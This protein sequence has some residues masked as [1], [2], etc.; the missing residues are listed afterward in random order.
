MDYLLGIDIGT[1]GTKSVL[2]DLEG[3]AIAS[4]LYEYPLYQPQNGWAEQDPEDWWKAVVQS[5]QDI[6]AESGVAPENII[7]IGLSGQM[8]GLVMLDEDCQVIR[9]S[10][11]WCDQRTS[12]ECDQVTDLVGRERLLEISANPALAG[13]TASK[14]LWVRNHEPENY[15]R[16]KKILLPKDYIRFKLTGEFATEVSDASGMQLLDIGNRCWSEEIL[17]RLNIDID[18]LGK[19]FESPE[20]TGKVTPEASTVTGLAVGTAVV[21]G[22]GDN[23]A[24]AVGMGVVE[25]GHAFA[26]IGTSGVVYAHTSAMRFDPLGRVHTFCCAVPGEWHVMGVTQAAGLSLQWFRNNF[27]AGEIQE[28]EEKGIDP[29]DLMINE[30]SAIPIGSNR[31]LYLPYL[32]GERTPHLD[33]DCRGVFFGLSASHTRADLTRAIMEGVT[34]SLFDSV[35]ILSEMGVA[36]DEI[37]ATGGGAK[38]ELWRM[39]MADVFNYPVNTVGS[40]SGPSLGVAILA[41]VGVGAYSSVKDACKQIIKR[42]QSVLTKKNNNEKYMEFYSIYHNLYPDLS[43]KFKALAKIRKN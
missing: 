1:S 10:I 30:A 7:G 12:V 36:F 16:C 13:F 17:E 20:V 14:I 21:G 34:F 3:G 11:I 5:C 35:R 42:N 24:S 22:A 25:D 18:L 9:R 29:Y 6:L 33:S 2:F 37:L 39:M 19:V 28:A 43:D 40:F 31:L 4:S 38:S 27:C 8:H 32:M 23:A 26:S 15:T 41:G